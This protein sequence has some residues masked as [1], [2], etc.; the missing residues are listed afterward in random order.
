MIIKERQNLETISKN[1]GKQKDEIVNAIPIPEFKG[2]DIKDFLIEWRRE[3]IEVYAESIVSDNDAPIESL[4]YWSEK[5][6]N[7]L[8]ELMLPLDIALEEISNYRET[9]SEIILKE[10]LNTDFS[11]ED[12]HKAI[13][14]FNYIVD[15]AIKLV[16]K[17]YMKD[18]NVTIAR[19]RYAVD[20]LSIPLVKITDSVGIIPIIGEIDTHRADQ[21]MKNGLSQ[22]SDEDLDYIIIDLSGVNAIDTMVAHQ[23]F[24]VI[25]SLELIGIKPILSGI[26][27]DIV[28][29]MVSLGINMSH[30]KTVSSLQQALKRIGVC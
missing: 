24:K 30:V 27:P 26:R 1:I 13:V 2:V 4:E 20:E 18:F 28:Q 21:L 12:Y 9:I 16:S 10:A 29:T 23:L 5:L 19:A 15:Q 17:K 25:E 6:S 8:L 11:L 14:N 7:R 22:G 3:L